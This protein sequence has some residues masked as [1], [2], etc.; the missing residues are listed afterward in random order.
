SNQNSECR[1][2]TNSPPAAK[3]PKAESSSSARL[4]AHAPAPRIAGIG[5]PADDRKP[6]IGIGASLLH[7]IPH[8]WCY[9]ETSYRALTAT[10]SDRL[11]CHGDSGNHFFLSKKEGIQGT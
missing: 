1:S 3:R 7:K 11:G 9:R 5:I 8:R 10:R 6:G 2:E 4:G